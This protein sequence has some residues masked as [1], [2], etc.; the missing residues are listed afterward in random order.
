MSEKI[1]SSVGTTISVA[2]G[3]PAT[4]DEAGYTDVS[5]VY[6]EVGAVENL[7]EF[8]GAA[9]TNSFTLLKTGQVIKRNGQIDYGEIT[10]NV[11]GIMDDP[12]Q[13]MMKAGF[14]GAEK[15]NVH[16][17]KISVPNQADFYVTGVI[18]SYRYNVA[19]ASSMFRCS[20]SIRIDNTPVI[21]LPA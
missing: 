8:G 6:T 18:G 21:V 15:G 1:T 12:G 11:A 17:F 4:Y 7:P 2:L 10:I 13:L 19:D 14:D 20:T 5:M 16:S 9:E 3:A